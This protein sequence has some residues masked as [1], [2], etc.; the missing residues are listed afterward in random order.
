[1]LRRLAPL[2]GAL[3]AT[4]ALLEAGAWLAV[5]TGLVRGVQRPSYGRDAYWW[6]DHPELGVWRRPNASF[7]HRAP[8]FDVTYHTNAVGARDIERTPEEHAPRVVVLGDSFLEGWGISDAQRLS[9]RLEAATGFEHL[10]LAMAHFGPFQELLAY[11][12]LA[13][14]FAHDAVLVGILPA[15]DFVDS[16]LALARALPDYEYRYRPYLVGDAPPYQRVDLREPRWRRALRSHSYAFGALLHAVSRG[17]SRA[18][19]SASPPAPSNAARRAPSWFYDYDE[20]GVQRLT[21]ILQQLVREAQGREVVVLLI[22]VLEDFRRQA[23]S[24]PD[25]LAARL[26]AAGVR[27]VDLLPVMADPRG[28][29]GRYFLSCDYH[30]SAEG[31]QVAS[32]R[33]LQAL[34]GSLYADLARRRADARGKGG[35]REDDGL[36]GPAAGL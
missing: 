26:E 35:A 14:A 32:E 33:V 20:A 8:C 34:R 15:N 7:E 5:E 11:R 1:V 23:L 19:A 25:P 18:A 2:L 9:N 36:P 10:N 22:P 27:V 21:W 6:G 3:V 17:G 4:L 29:W 28:Q 16:D 12:T 13:K 31:N 24:G 30:W